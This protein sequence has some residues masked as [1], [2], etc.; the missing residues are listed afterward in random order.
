MGTAIIVYVR[1]AA[2]CPGESMPRPE[3]REARILDNDVAPVGPRD[4]NKRSTYIDE[5]RKVR[6]LGAVVGARIICDRVESTR[7][8]QPEYSDSAGPDPL[9]KHFLGSRVGDVEG[10][11]AVTF[12]GRGNPAAEK[13][14]GRGETAPACEKF[15]K[16]ATWRQLRPVSTAAASVEVSL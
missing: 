15:K 7:D 6:L 12:K 9:V 16:V 14:D 3:P 11:A 4:P 1:H 13:A 5:S 8:G 2:H 10:D